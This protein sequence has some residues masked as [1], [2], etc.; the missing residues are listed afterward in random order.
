MV[1]GIKLWGGWTNRLRKYLDRDAIPGKKFHLVYNLGISG[2][3]TRDWLGHFEEEYVARTKDATEHRDKTVVLF[4]LCGNDSA[5]LQ[6]QKNNWVPIEEFECNIR[7]LLGFAKLRASR[8]FWV[9]D[10]PINKKVK[11][12]KNITYYDKT[13][14]EYNKAAEIVCKEEKVPFID[15]Y[16]R[17]KESKNFL[18][19]DELHLNSKGHK[20]IFETVRD[21]LVKNRI[22]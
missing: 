19:S 9:A 12:T 16:M 14:A 5:Y 10:H 7:K 15:V 11:W 4:T 8:I 13:I 17:L 20:I 18:C 22:I 2:H 3:T 6:S 21:F 1:R